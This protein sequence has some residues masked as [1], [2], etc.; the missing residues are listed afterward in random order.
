MTK[1]TYVRQHR[2]VLESLRERGSMATYV[3]RNTV[4]M[5]EGGGLAKW[6]DAT[7][8]AVLRACRRLERQGLVEQVSTSY[9]VMLSWRITQNGRRVLTDI[10]V[11]DA[12]HG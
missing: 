1:S 10:E 11:T 5:R 3:I 4:A 8:S 7:T 2:A 9:R 6:P 12:T